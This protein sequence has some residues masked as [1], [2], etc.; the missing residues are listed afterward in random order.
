MSQNDFRSIWVSYA[1]KEQT[2]IDDLGQAVQTSQLGEEKPFALYAYVDKPFNNSEPVKYFLKTGE[3][4]QLVIEQIATSLRRVI[5]LSPAYLNSEH[6]LW[7]LCCCLTYS[8]NNLFLVLSDIGDFADL[9]KQ[10]A[11]T[12][13]GSSS[14]LVEALCKTYE[15]KVIEMHSSFHIPSGQSS[16]SFFKEKLAGLSASVH[17]PAQPRP[18]N[19]L[20]EYA[21][22]FSLEQL[23]AKFDAFLQRCFEQWQTN[24]SIDQAITLADLQDDKQD[25]IQ[26]LVDDL[27]KQY[28][29]KAKSKAV[30]CQLAA[31]LSLLR[32]DPQWLAEMRDANPGAHLLRISVP[33][34]YSDDIR[35][36]YEA[37][38][39]A[40]AIQ[41]VP[42]ELTAGCEDIPDVGG[43]ESIVIP[44]V[45]ITEVT[46]K[47]ETKQKLKDELVSRVMVMQDNELKDFYARRDWRKRFRAVI[48]LKHNDEHNMLTIARFYLDQALF[49]QKS[50][51]QGIAIIQEIMNDINEKAEP[52]RIVKIGVLQLL[53]KADCNIKYSQDEDLLQVHITDLL[54][55]L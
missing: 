8:S 52:N 24:A 39:A 22:S 42:I 16:E 53:D 3:L 29:N 26:P 38:L 55:A 35:K 28:E 25:K 46:L 10:N 34:D 32:L 23:I 50:N 33:E 54:G 2:L 7:E 44:P 49:T 51:T 4:I 47:E 15:T 40:H 14:T 36:A 6:C 19:E 45:P 48:K 31:I 12:Y 37:N 43:M 11:F 30:L 21:D 13:Y 18:T 5:V 17:W 27:I 20:V 9:Q 1:S 41:M